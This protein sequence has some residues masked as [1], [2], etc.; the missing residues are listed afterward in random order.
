MC[1]VNV[2]FAITL[3]WVTNVIIDSLFNGCLRLDLDFTVK[4]GL[5]TECSPFAGAT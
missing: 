2:N 3:E 5:G 1:T 4:G